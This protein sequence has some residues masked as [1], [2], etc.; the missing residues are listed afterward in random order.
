MF[1]SAPLSEAVQFSCSPSGKSNTFKV[2]CG[3][4]ANCAL[5]DEGYNTAHFQGAHEEGLTSMTLKIL[6]IPITF[7]RNAEIFQVHHILAI[8]LLYHSP[9]TVHLRGSS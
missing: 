9:N 5:V 8:W 3:N 4:P 7:T 2:L 1:P 6:C